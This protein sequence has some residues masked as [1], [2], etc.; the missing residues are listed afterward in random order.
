MKLARLEHVIETE[1]E[2]FTCLGTGACALLDDP[3]FT[4]PLKSAPRLSF[5]GH[6][7][8]DELCRRMTD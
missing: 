4:G 5:L 6:V 3:L 8:I 1:L 2:V 7:M